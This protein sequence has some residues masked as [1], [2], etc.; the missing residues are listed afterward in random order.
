MI[1]T[2][3]AEY[4]APESV[5]RAVEGM[6]DDTALDELAETFASLSEPTR[7]RI[8]YAL[9]RAELCVCDLSRA[10]GIT[11]SNCSHQLRRLKLLRLVRSR[12]DGKHVY[13]ALDDAHIHSLFVDGLEHVLEQ[14]RL[15]RRDGTQREDRSSRP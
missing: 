2:K 5:A 14:P 4:V 7:L 10:L 11:E 15:P 8:L 9:S 1:D 6:P 13:Y 12:K 3:Q